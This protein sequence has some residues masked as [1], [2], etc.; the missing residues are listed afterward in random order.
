MTTNTNTT[1]A[2]KILITVGNGIQQEVDVPGSP[3]NTLNGLADAINAAKIGVV[4]NV[5]T[6]NGESNLM[7]QSQ[8]AGLAGTLSVL[9]QLVATSDKPLTYSS[10]SG[11]NLASSTGTL[12]AVAGASDVLMGS[13]AIRVGGGA[14]TTVSLASSGGTLQDLADAI[15]NTAGI[16]ASASVSS[17]GTTLTLASQ[18]PGTTGALTVTSSLLD[19]TD[20][21]TTNLDYTNSSDVSTLSA[22]GVSMNNDGTISFDASQLD[23]LLNTDFTGVV[24]M[25]QGINSWGVG[26]SNMLNSSGSGSSSGILTLTQSSNSNIEKTLNAN[27]AK[28]D[29]LIAAQQKSLTAEL[30]RANEILQALPSQLNGIDELYAAISGYSS[31]RSG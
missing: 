29:A 13:I 4:A 18:T 8:T 23:A 2:G 24:G 26:F 17:D 21:A 9:P 16:G 14:A 19:S 3:N 27:I 25:L 28:E 20:T 22:L 30:N 10:S 31:S 12:T 15:N 1:I 6:K 5:V 11:T 7:L